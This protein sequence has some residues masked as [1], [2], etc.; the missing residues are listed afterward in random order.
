DLENWWVERRMNCR[1]ALNAGQPRVA[2][3]IA[4]EHG[5]LTGDPLVEA[6]FLAGWIA[7]RF[8]SEPKDALIHFI[9][10]RGAAS[11]SKQIALG[12]YWLGRTAPG[13]GGRRHTHGACAR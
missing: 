13:V 9:A 11:S 2:Y 4:V 10:L 3:E 7:L 1:T 8:L 6:D 12:E 5:P